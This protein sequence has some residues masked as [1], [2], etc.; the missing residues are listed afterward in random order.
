[1]HGVSCLCAFLQ[2]RDVLSSG[3][4]LV[5]YFLI[6]VALML[7]PLICELTHIK[8]TT[9]QAWCALRWF[10]VCT[11]LV[12]LSCSPHTVSSEPGWDPR[13]TTGTHWDPRKT[14]VLESLL[15]TRPED[16]P[17]RDPWVPGKPLIYF[18]AACQ[19]RYLLLLSQVVQS[20]YKY[21]G[22][23]GGD[24]LFITDPSLKPHFHCV[25]GQEHFKI[26]FHV[27]E[28]CPDAKDGDRLRIYG[29]ASRMRVF[30]WPEVDQYSTLL[31]LDTDVLVLKNIYPLL[32]AVGAGHQLSAMPEGRVCDLYHAGALLHRFAMINRSS[33]RSE[34]AGRFQASLKAISDIGC[35]AQSFNT[36][37]ILIPNTIRMRE[38]CSSVMPLIQKWHGL[39][40]PGGAFT[41]MEQP[42]ITYQ[43]HRYR[44]VNFSAVK[45]YTANFN[46]HASSPQL[47]KTLKA[48]KT[49]PDL[50]A[51]CFIPIAVPLPPPSP[52]QHLWL[53]ITVC[54]IC[55]E[56]FLSASACR[57]FV[58]PG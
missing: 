16:P 32:R 44:A 33:T 7:S 50:K 47:G 29:A 1:M 52:L 55:W 28:S 34:N 18:V 27:L 36:G 41:T 57:W 58:S 3:A 6:A 48:L 54:S 19:H 5:A 31:Y 45:K 24:V 51:S 17:A 12:L 35:E 9:G 14:K 2:G 38:L 4:H 21:G 15:F 25:P 42:F 30:E 22:Y 43:A 23:E 46:L 26:H 53:C 13:N 10:G 49:R 11:V 40:L 20:L 39:N 56:L 37:V 8:T